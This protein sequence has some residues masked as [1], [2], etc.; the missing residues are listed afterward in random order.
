MK[1]VMIISVILA[2]VCVGKST[3]Y[4]KITLSIQR[5]DL[6]GWDSRELENVGRGDGHPSYFTL[7][8][9]RSPGSCGQQANIT[10]RSKK[11]TQFQVGETKSK[12]S[13]T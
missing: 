11:G 12:I 10:L 3:S 2:L 4:N 1:A 9:D 5:R 6:S 7:F 8:F 13:G